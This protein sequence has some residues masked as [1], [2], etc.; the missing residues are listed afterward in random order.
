MDQNRI[1]ELATLISQNVAKL[2]EYLKTNGLPGPTFDIETPFVNNFPEEIGSLRNAVL[3]ANLELSELLLGP[4]ETFV[5]YQVGNSFSSL[6]FLLLITEVACTNPKWTERLIDYNIV[7]L[8][9]LH[10]SFI[11]I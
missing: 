7:Q 9:C 3:E 1:V 8:F 10:A 5:E 4:K 6:S 2:D 11:S